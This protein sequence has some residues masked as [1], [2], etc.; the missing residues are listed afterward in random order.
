MGL[1]KSEILY[2]GDTNTDMET[3]NN[4]KVDTVG[5]TWGFQGPGKSLRSFHPSPY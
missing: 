4:A 2:L 5:V 3:G 1:S